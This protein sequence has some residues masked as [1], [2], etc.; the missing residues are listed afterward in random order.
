MKAKLFAILFCFI[1]FLVFPAQ[2]YA[3]NNRNVVKDQAENLVNLS[4]RVF[5]YTD[6]NQDTAAASLINEL[7]KQWNTAAPYYSDRDKHVVDAAII[8]LKLLLNSDGDQSEKVDAAVSLRL[9]FDALQ[10]DGQ[11]LW[12]SLHSEVLSPVIKMKNALKDKDNDR[13][14]STLNHFLDEY[15]LIYPAMMIDGQPDAINLVDKRIT[16]FTDKR[17]LDVNASSRI[18]Q[19]NSIETELNQ[20]FEQAS[21]KQEDLITLAAIIGGLVLSVLAYASW[22]RFLAERVRRRTR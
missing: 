9:C 14:Q 3:E 18:R 7:D 11:P 17:L 21:N 5:Q 4:D 10:S 1:L 20:V 6:A 8:K 19:L 22:R 15:A 16:S 13:F 12:K 2:G